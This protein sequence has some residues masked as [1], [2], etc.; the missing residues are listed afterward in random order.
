M[1]ALARKMNFLV[2]DDSEQIRNMTVNVL[3]DSGIPHIFEANTGEAGWEILQKGNIDVV[4]CNWIMSE[5][6]G[7]ELLNLNMKD[8]KL[9]KHVAFIM[10]TTVD[11]KNSIVKAISSGA[12]G[13]LIKPFDRQHLFEQIFRVIQWVEQEKAH[14]AKTHKK[15]GMVKPAF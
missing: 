12:R 8:P 6:D 7:I 3:R 4:L 14:E 13:Y 2:V 1:I 9:A 11:D 5:M 15:H 10:L